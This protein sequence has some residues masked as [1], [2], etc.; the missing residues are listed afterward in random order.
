MSGADMPFTI[1]YHPDV[2]KR[3][4]PAINANVHQRLRRAV[5]NRLMV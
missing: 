4:I 5:E 3:D 1:I 2:K